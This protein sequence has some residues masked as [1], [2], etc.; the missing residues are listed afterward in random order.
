MYVIQIILSA[1]FHT[2]YKPIF[3]Q[4]G[5]FYFIEHIQEWDRSSHGY[6]WILQHILT[7]FKIWPFLFEGCNLNRNPLPFIQSV[8]FSDVQYERLYAPMPAK[9]FMIA[10]PHLK[11]IATK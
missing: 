6:R 11:G 1:F 5:R 7:W 10:S 2:I 3:L 8:G 9:V 4:G